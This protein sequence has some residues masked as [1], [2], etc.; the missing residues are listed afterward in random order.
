M[1]RTWSRE[2]SDAMAWQSPDVSKRQIPA[3]RGVNTS[4]S[5]TT[6]NTSAHQI[7]A[8]TSVT[9]PIPSRMAGARR[10]RFWVIR[11]IGRTLELRPETQQLQ[12]AMA[13]FC[14]LRVG[15]MTG[16]WQIHVDDLDDRRGARAHHDDALG[17]QQSLLDVMRHH[18][19]REARIAP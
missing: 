3:S 1:L 10:K 11:G 8:M 2:Q 19:A 5:S 17:H 15:A 6:L 16:I 18:Q 4:A 13:Q 12:C 14:E 7:S 9:A